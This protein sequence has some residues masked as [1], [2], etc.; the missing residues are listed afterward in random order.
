MIIIYNEIKYTVKVTC[1]GE[2]E[3]DAI[4]WDE[5][6]YT[7]EQNQQIFN[8]SQTSH[9]F[10]FVKKVANNHACSGHR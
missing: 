5:S 10:H 8:Q 1:R 4:D 9:F 6:L 7:E 3:I 2:F